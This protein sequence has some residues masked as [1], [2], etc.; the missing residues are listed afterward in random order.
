ME[1]GGW[2]HYCGAALLRGGDCLSG[3]R[4]CDVPVFEWPRACVLSR[5]DN[6][7]ENL[8]DTGAPFYDVYT[9]KD[10][11]HLAVYVIG[12]QAGGRLVPASH[13][14]PLHGEAG[15]VPTKP[16]VLPSLQLASSH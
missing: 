3:E 8:L 1:G 16:R 12:E 4:P 6:V 9:T 7:G 15:P 14:Q 13:L 5:S 2:V 11:K 10:G